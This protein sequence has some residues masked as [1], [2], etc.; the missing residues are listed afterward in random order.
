MSA[1][2]LIVSFENVEQEIRLNKAG[3]AIRRAGVKTVIGVTA[4]VE[5]IGDR[6]L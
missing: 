2:T 5:F 3:E 1:K 4:T 6:A